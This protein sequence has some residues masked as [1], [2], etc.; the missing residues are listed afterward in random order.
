M[1]VTP[2]T[3]VNSKLRALPTLHARVEIRSKSTADV[4]VSSNL[5]FDGQLAC[6]SQHMSRLSYLISLDWG[7]FHTPPLMS[8]V[9][10][11]MYWAGPAGGA[12]LCLCCYSSS[13]GPVVI[14]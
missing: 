6:Q 3:Y 8:V 9:G 12:W 14:E 4:S 10:R 5:P 13:E 7:T 2:P 11:Y 1:S